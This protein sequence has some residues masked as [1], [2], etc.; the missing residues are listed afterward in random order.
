MHEEMSATNG[1]TTLEFSWGSQETSPVSREIRVLLSTLHQI[2]PYQKA[3][4][5]L[6]TCRD[7]VFLISRINSETLISKIIIMAI[8]FRIFSS[9]VADDGVVQ[10]DFRKLDHIHQ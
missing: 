4:N 10:M 6:C 5:C 3:E 1:Y 8:T 9:N 7:T 2:F